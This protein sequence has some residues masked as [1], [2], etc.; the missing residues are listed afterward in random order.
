[1]A[2]APQRRQGAPSTGIRRLLAL[3]V[4]GQNPAPSARHA[5]AATPACLRPLEA[6]VAP[7]FKST[8]GSWNKEMLAELSARLHA[9]VA[10][11]DV[12][13]ARWLISQGADPLWLNED[14]ECTLHAACTAGNVE[15]IAFLV[16]D[17]ARIGPHTTCGDG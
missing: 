14:L 15:T 8:D 2:S 4:E 7:H 1:M 16:D 9:A 10:R 12:G 3:I 13:A 6:C 11:G 17:W 5:A